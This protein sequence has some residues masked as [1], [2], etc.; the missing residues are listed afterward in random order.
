MGHG[1]DGFMRQATHVSWELDTG[2]A[3]P[4]GK[5]ALHSCD[6]PPCVN[7]R[8]IRPASRLENARDMAEKGRGSI[9]DANGM[10]RMP[11]NRRHGEDHWLAALNEAK[12]RE[13]RRLRTEGLGYTLIARAIGSNETTV[14]R[15][16][17][18][19]TWRHVE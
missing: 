4:T 11:L 3:W 14:K 10:R 6:N 18:G 2:E 8:H 1:G 19:Q 17:K 7:P 16:I 12:V 15:V 9:G 5:E 13:I